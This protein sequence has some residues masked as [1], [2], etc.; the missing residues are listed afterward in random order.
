MSMASEPRPPASRRRIPAPVLLLAALAAWL[1][2]CDDPLQERAVEA[3]G[4]E[5]FDV[6][7]GPLHRPGQPCVLCH[8]GED[9]RAFSVAGTVYLTPDSDTPAAGASVGLVDAKGAG[10]VAI[11]NCAGNFFVLP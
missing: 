1:V 10:F 2:G 3:L 4:P 8:D 5:P 11:T 6:P 9:A 7:E